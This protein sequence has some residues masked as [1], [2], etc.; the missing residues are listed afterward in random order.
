MNIEQHFPPLIIVFFLIAAFIIPLLYRWR[1]SLAAPA[2][3]LSFCFS[4]AMTVS[5][6][7]RLNRSGSFVYHLGGWAPPWGIE[8]Q[9]DFLRIYMLL[10]I[11]GLGLWIFVF[12]LRAL[13]NE[14]KKE[15]IGW[16]YCL[17][18]LLMGSMAGMALTNDLF[19][20]FV[21]MEIAA[22]SSCA[23]ISIKESREC[24]EASFKY[25]ILSAMGTG[26]YLLAVAMIYMV[27]GHL[28]FTL[29]RE[30]LPEAMA[31]YPNNI[32]VAASLIIVAFGTKA[33]LFPLHVWLPD[34][35]ASA[36]SPSSAVLSGLVIKIYAFGMLLLFYT[37][38]PRAL[39]DMVPLNEIVLWLATLGIVFGSI[40]AMV[41]D[42]LK[43]MLA[44]SSIAQ[45]GYIFMGIGLDNRTALIGGLYHLLSHGVM[46][47]MLFM[48]AG[49]IIH[50]AGVRKIKDLNG[51]GKSL[52]LTMIAFSIAGASM[53][54]IPGT[55]GLIGKWFLALGALEM[56][57]PFF[58]LVILLSSLL[59]AVYYLPITVNAFL[60]PPLGE[61]KFKPVPRLMLACLIV[62][63]AAVVFFGVAPKLTVL[64]LERALDIIM[65]L[66]AP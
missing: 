37:V 29:V 21:F 53:I 64:L 34:A 33:A 44:Y 46:K 22:I 30:A 13:E 55:G 1:S 60:N 9:V 39:L 23:I 7:F 26:C 5:L 16:Y 11:L 6:L 42:D 41:Q 57:R 51:I 59:N 4:I 14:L 32:L 43:K 38:F 50:A 48:T 19:N 58:V 17:F 66:V 28:N 27:T 24:L 54:G 3:L 15:V 18:A 61:K 47:V 25:L 45:I 56:E 49:I 20:M 31:L 62:G 10:V 35:H 12:A 36:P 2:L 40:F 8:L 65:P 63:I 52:P